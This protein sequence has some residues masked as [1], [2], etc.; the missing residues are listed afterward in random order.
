[1]GDYREVGIAAA[2]HFRLHLDVHFYADQLNVSGRYLAQVTRRISGKTR[3]NPA[4]RPGRI[5]GFYGISKGFPQ[6]RELLD[7]PKKYQY[8]YNCDTMWAHCVR[9]KNSER[10]D[11]NGK[12]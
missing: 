10:N 5:V 1:M 6:A 3:R 4:V 12:V 7:I 11:T 2:G 9:N 8:H